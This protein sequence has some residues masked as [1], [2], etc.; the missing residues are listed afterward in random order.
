MVEAAGSGENWSAGTYSSAK[1]GMGKTSSG[2]SP[3]VRWRLPTIYDYKLADVNGIRFVMP[4]MVTTSSGYEWSASV[5]AG[6]RDYA[7]IVDG[8]DGIVVPTTRYDPYDVRCA[9]R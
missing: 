4:E 1:G 8:A 5:Y 2:T 7:W 3:S 6:N 9:G